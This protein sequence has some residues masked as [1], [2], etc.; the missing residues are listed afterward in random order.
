MKSESKRRQEVE[1]DRESLRVKLNDLQNSTQI[2][3]EGLYNEKEIY[4]FY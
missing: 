4:V 1:Q 2:I 3:L